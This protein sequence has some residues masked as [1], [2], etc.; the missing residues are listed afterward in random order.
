MEREELEAQYGKVWTTDN[1]SKDF[2]VH[3]FSA[4]FCTVT[5]RITGKKGTLEFQHRPRYYFDFRE[6]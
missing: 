4:P 6:N 3:S 2:T 5:S 1:L